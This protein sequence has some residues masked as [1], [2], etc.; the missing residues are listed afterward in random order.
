MAT[1]QTGHDTLTPEKEA[2]NALVF[3][4]EGLKTLA[5]AYSIYEEWTENMDPYAPTIRHPLYR[6]IV[7]TYHGKR[8]NLLQTLI[9]GD[10]FAQCM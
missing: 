6:Q 2:E 4:Q 10:Y 3:F 9:Q 8:A 1:G 7:R 5:S